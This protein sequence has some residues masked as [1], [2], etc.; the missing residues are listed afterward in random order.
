MV[1]DVEPGLPAKLRS[2]PLRSGR[3]LL[4]PSGT[5]E[6]VVSMDGVHEA[7]LDLTVDTAGPDPGLA[8]RARAEFD[9]LVKVQA[10]YPRAEQVASAREGRTLEELYAAFHETHEGIPASEE[11]LAAFREVQEEASRATP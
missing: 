11:L 7:Y 1:V 4:R 5:W 10:A 8:E 6:H 2:V 9:Y 3:R